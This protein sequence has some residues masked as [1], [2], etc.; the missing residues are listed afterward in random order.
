VIALFGEE[1][2][3]VF[4]RAT[5]MT[6]LKGDA[7]F[8]TAKKRADHREDLD[9]F[10]GGW[11]SGKDVEGVVHLLQEAG[12]AAGVVQNAE[13]L[14]HDPQL[15]AGDFFVELPHP[16]LGTA[17]S[18]RPPFRL[19]DGEAASWKAAPLLGDDNDYVFRGLLG[20]TEDE[21]RSAMA[22]GLIR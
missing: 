22:G 2:W 11:T 13:D 12:I 14:A 21:V 18:E 1:D 6:D 7:R 19:V 20:F 15:M 3:R 8:S 17:V 9:R 4:C 16:V 5:G 10:I